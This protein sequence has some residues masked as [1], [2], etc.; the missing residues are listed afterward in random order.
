MN[1]LKKEALVGMRFSAVYYSVLSAID[2]KR[3]LKAK[4][5]NEYATCEHHSANY[6]Q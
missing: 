3:V 2:L 5:C 1:D 4:A 6:F